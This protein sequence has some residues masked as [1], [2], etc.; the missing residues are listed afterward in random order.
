LGADYKH[1]AS[2]AY[3]GAIIKI[4]YYMWLSGYTNIKYIKKYIN[5]EVKVFNCLYLGIYLYLVAQLNH[6]KMLVE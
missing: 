2:I 4:N 1:I 6:F 3:I 5:K